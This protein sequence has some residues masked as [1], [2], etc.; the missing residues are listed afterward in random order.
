MLLFLLAV[1]PIIFL[2][3]TLGIVKMSGYK[4]CILAMIL[5]VLEVLFVFKA[6]IINVVTGT[7]E[8]IAMAIWP[9]CLVIVAAVFTYNLVVYTK[10][11]ETIKDMLAS[12]SSDK[13]ILI[14]IIAWGFGAFMEGM[15]GFGTAVAIPA[16]ILVGLGF[17][18]FFAATVCL[19]ANTTPVTFGSIGV[20]E[21]TA[22][23]ITGLN[24]STLAIY[25]ILQTMVM[26]I[27]VPFMIVYMVGKCTKNKMIDTF[28]D[29]WIIILSSGIFFVIGEYFTTRLINS[30][31]SSVIG[32]IV[33]M[34]V[35][36]I[37]TKLLNVNNPKFNIETSKKNVTINLKQAFIAWSPFVFVLV[38]LIFTS[39][40]IPI[41]NQTLLKFKSSIVIYSGKDA[42]PYTFFWL[43]TPGVQIIIAT[44]LGGI[45]QKCSIKGIICVFIKTIKQ[46]T[47]TIITIISVIVTAKLMG[48]CGMIEII[49]DFI[50]DITGNFYPLMAAF[51]GSVGTFV[52]GSATS[53]AVLFAK[54]QYSAANTLN[55]D[56]A[57]MVAANIT[58]STAGKIISPQ[59]ITIAT[60]AAGIS[61]VES[62]ILIKVIKYYALFIII[63]GTVVYFGIKIL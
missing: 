28:K 18:P 59:S 5:T 15:A 56:S 48:Y 21:M 39:S 16:S 3:F 20:P 46:L 24:V 53:S 42:K 40:L 50:V 31:L 10:K 33:S 44:V 35:I 6:P 43:S 61:G 26:S 12:V 13:R 47:K 63:Y 9:I 34:I 17:N 49:A 30:E 19:V 22:A 62:K 8:G 45:V 32:A 51:L 52:T 55:V 1:L 14:L 41:I 4:A 54:L 60:A 58:G 38:F 29:I 2:I 27:V 37:L 23:N 36:I 57:W 7:I 11:I 25:T